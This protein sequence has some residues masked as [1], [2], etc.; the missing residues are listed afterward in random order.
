M[1]SIDKT[2]R[3]LIPALR[4]AEPDGLISTDAK[5][6]IQVRVECAQRKQ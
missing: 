1:A 2:L 5:V 6:L 4:K 3:Q